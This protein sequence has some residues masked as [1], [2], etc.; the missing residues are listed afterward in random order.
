M[1]HR[2]GTIQNLTNMAVYN[3]YTALSIICDFKFQFNWIERWWR[4]LHQWLEKFF[5]RQLMMLLE[6]GHYDPDMEVVR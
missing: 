1:C 5:K 6:Q 2:L 4:E 3:L